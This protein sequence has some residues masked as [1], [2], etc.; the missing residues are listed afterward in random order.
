[1]STI[2]Q[3][4]DRAGLEVLGD[5][6]HGHVQDGGV[7]GDEQ[8]AD[9]EDDEYDPAVGAGAG[10]PTAGWSGGRGRPGHVRTSQ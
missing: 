4:L 8:Q 9:A 7:D 1:M 10:V 5:G 6:G 3:Q 2:Q